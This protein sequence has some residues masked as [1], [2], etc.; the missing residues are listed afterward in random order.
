MG[1]TL[2]WR[3]EQARVERRYGSIVEFGGGAARGTEGFTVLAPDLYDGPVVRSCAS[4]L[5]HRRPMRSST[6]SSTTFREGVA[7]SHA[8][9]NLIMRRPSEQGGAG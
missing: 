7:L 4:M 1:V 8:L 6:S 5:P 9:E 2:Q 3:N